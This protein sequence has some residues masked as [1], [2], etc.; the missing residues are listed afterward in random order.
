MTKL[1]L[2]VAA[3]CLA[4]SPAWAGQGKDNIAGVARADFDLETLTI[5]CVKVENLDDDLDGKYY[6]VELE[7]RG[8]SFN[9]ELKLAKPEDSA[10]CEKV[11]N[12]SKFEDDDFDDEDSSDD[13]ASTSSDTSKIFVSCERETD[14][15]EVSVNA[16]NLVPG[17]YSAMIT[18]GA[19]TA[20]SFSMPSD[21]DEVEFDFDSDPD[22][23]MEGDNEIGPDFI[24]Q[25]TVSAEI[26]DAD[27]ETVVSVDAVTCE[28]DDDSS[29]D[30]S[31]D[32]DSSDDDSSD[33]D[34]SDDDS[35]APSASKDR[36]RP[37]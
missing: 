5:P 9:F 29:D 37:F 30:D 20:T 15:S 14:R 28:I 27:S 18:S 7:R 1:G 3:I 25:G 12:F 24:Q 23:I 13:D 26:F 31:S 4:S 34:S 6:D 33:D 16:K 21:D 36:G 19:N 32:D 17:N 2:V 35:S 10:Y 8:K 11:N 22:D